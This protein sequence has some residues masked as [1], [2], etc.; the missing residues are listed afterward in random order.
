MADN[1]LRRGLIADAS[2]AN[3]WSSKL[4]QQGEKVWAEGDM[5][6]LDQFNKLMVNEERIETFLMPMFDGL[7]M[8]RMK[9]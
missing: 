2:E 6:A 5:K 1:I 9:N 3:P 8:G 4:K 7:G